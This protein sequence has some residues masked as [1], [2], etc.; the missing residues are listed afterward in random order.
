MT[1]QTDTGPAYT[2]NA[3][4]LRQAAGALEDQREAERGPAPPPAA[5]PVPQLEGEDYEN[6]VFD[7]N[8]ARNQVFHTLQEA[9]QQLGRSPMDA[10]TAGQLLAV[11]RQ[12]EQQAAAQQAADPDLDT[13]L[14]QQQ[15]AEALAAQRSRALLSQPLSATAHRIDVLA[16]AWRR[17]LAGQR[18]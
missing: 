1:E 15:Q 2:S 5:D 8:Q 13:I 11:L 6:A 10:K 12:E 9:R 14:G 17:I 18:Q 4:G 16:T 7:R 3:E